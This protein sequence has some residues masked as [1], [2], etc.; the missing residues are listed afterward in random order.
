M[1]LHITKNDIYVLFEHTET[2]QPPRT[3]VTK[4]HF[5][6][7]CLALVYFRQADLIQIRLLDVDTIASCLKKTMPQF[8]RVVII[9]PEGEFS[10]YFEHAMSLYSIQGVEAALFEGMEAAKAWLL[11]S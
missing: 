9:R 8:T 5:G 10:D 1:P 2:L 7:C 3:K 6:D 11:S 4:Q